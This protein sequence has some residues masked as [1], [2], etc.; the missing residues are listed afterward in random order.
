MSCPPCPLLAIHWL[1]ALVIVGVSVAI[2]ALPNTMR[3]KGGAARKR[4]SGIL[5]QYNTTLQSML[6]GVRLIKAYRCR[7]V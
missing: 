2:I 7:K 6:E 5:G 1:L 4:Y 3:K